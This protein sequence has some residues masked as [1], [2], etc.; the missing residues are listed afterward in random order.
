MWVCAGP[1][2]AS[3]GPTPPL[4]V[5]RLFGVGGRHPSVD[6]VLQEPT[7]DG[8]LRGPR[9]GR[10]LPH[11]DHE[12]GGFAP[13]PNLTS[14]GH[15]VVVCDGDQVEARFDRGVHELRRRDH[16]VRCERVAMRIGDEHY[17]NQERTNDSGSNASRSSMP[18]PT[19]ASLTGTSTSFSIAIT[20][21]PLALPSSLA[22]TSPVMGIA[23]LNARA[24][25]RLD[26]PRTASSTS[27]DS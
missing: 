1:A 16:A 10:L 12:P 21:P 27:S 25:A 9:G 26:S 8:G 19:P 7:E 11:H 13:L 20:A 4:G 17:S 23:L 2:G 24:W 5:N 18:S 3:S 22:R 6:R 14:G 15:S